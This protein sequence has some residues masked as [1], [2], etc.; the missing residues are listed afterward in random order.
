MEKKTTINR[1][2]ETEK[3]V[4]VKTRFGET[5]STI[6]KHQIKFNTPFIMHSEDLLNQIRW[7][8]GLNKKR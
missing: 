5:V 7:G 6:G 8:L 4:I 3:I 2:E 1:V